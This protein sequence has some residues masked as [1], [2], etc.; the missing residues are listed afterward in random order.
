MS[1]N[2]PNAYPNYAQVTWLISAPIG[3][4][5]NLQFHSFHVRINVD[6]IKIKINM[7]SYSFSSQTQP[8]DTFVDF[9]PLTIYDGSNDQSTQIA[10]LSGHLESFGISSTGNSLFVKFESDGTGQFSG[11]HVTIHYGNPHSNIK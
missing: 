8:P 3:S 4:I 11:F 6:S 5:I 9:D 1:P 2:Y 10:K 7:N